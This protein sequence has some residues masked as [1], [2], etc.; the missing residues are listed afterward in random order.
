M[1]SAGGIVT[2]V[3][4]RD[5]EIREMWAAENPDGAELLDAIV[6]WL[7]R[8]IAVTD[9]DDLNILALWIVHTHLVVECYTTPR[10]QIDS[11]IYE[12]GK[13]TTLEHLRHLCHAPIHSAASS[14]P[15]LMARLL[16]SR[17]RTILLDEV[18]RTLHPDKPGVGDMLAIINAGYRMGA[19]R[20]VLVPVKGGGWDSA[21][22][23]VY[24]PVAMAGNAPNLPADTVSRCIRI[25]LMPDLHGTVEDSDWENISGE[26][27]ELQAAIAAWADIVRADLKGMK[28]DLPKGCTGR[29]REKWRP[30]KRVAVAAGGDWPDIV[31]RLVVRS[32]AEDAAIRDAGLKAQPPGMV[33]LAD[34][35]AVWPEG[36]HADL[37]SAE[38]LVNLLVNHN[39]A[40]WGE[41]SPYGKRLTE[42]RMGRLLSQAAKVTSSRP[43]GGGQPRGYL[44]S[45]L[46][47]V[48]RSLKI[49]KTP[50]IKGE[51]P[52]VESVESVPAVTT[53]TTS[54]TAMT[55][56]P[57]STDS[58][59]DTPDAEATACRYCG[60]PI[61]PHMRSQVARGFCGRTTCTATARR[62]LAE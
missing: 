46:L 9:R 54:Q 36:E 2:A 18:D 38:G 35:Y 60:D 44:R 3:E 16:E 7:H 31:D 10:L 61:A 59:T 50:P 22:M 24:A 14:S 57:T 1:V 58:Q 53:V 15:A 47:P 13:S 49:A 26:A 33:L 32:M 55:D 5:D 56:A 11:V 21:E 37:M 30:M 20:P 42:Q 34:L 19:T 43:G 39:P 8:F 41:H 17:M 4:N 51:T 62:D 23:P 29:S 28:V 27:E 52:L 40:Y 25:L 6:A 12:A 45:H 48:W